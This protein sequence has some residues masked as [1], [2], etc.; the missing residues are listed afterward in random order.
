MS[1]REVRLSLNMTQDDLVN[2]VESYTKHRI[3]KKSVSNCENGH[4]IKEL[5]AMRVLNTVNMLYRIRKRPELS[6]DDL[7]WKISDRRVEPEEEDP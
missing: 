7:T 2:A 3:A 5:T 6:I 4:P 1:L